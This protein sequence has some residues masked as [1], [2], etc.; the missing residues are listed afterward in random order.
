MPLSTKDKVII[1]HYCLDKDYGVK[2]LLKDFPNKGW[3]KGGLSHLLRKI[4]KTGYF[5]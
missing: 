2:R 1:Q 4:D 5:P 3:K